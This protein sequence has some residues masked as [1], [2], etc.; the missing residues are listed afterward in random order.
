MALWGLAWLGSTPVGGSL[1]GWVGQEFGARWPLI[2]GG[3]PTIVVGIATYPVLARV[4]A[5]R[6]R[7]RQAQEA[8][9][10]PATSEPEPGPA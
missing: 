2:I 1:V 9:V 3:L 7:A 8:G 6:A 4:D 10:G 5:R